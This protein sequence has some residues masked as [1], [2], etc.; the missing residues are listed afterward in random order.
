MNRREFLGTSGRTLAALA[1]ASALPGC[2]EG[3]NE[4]AGGSPPPAPSLGTA[5]AASATSASDGPP[6]R[7][8]L[9][10]W[11]LNRSHFGDWRTD[12][13]DAAG[14]EFIRR[15]GEAPATVLEGPLDPLDFP[16]RAAA[17]GFGGVE[18][19]NTFYYANGNDRGYLRELRNRAV[20]AG[21]ENVLIMCDGEGDLGAPALDDR[22]A[23]VERHQ[24]WLDAAEILGCHA[25]RVNA[26]S[27]GTREEQLAHAADGL[28]RLCERAE[29]QGLH[30]LVENHGGYSSD[31]AW[32]MEVMER[33]GHPL[34]GT[35]PDFGNFEPG[36]DIYQSVRLMM[37]LARAVSAKSYNFDEAGNE[38]TID[39]ARMMEIVRQAGYVGWV[40]VEYEGDRLREEEGIIAT[41]KL[42]ERLGVGAP[43]TAG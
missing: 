40:G 30:I 20:D 2:N 8:S 21:T 35:L 31:A 6:S 3:R 29:D 10:Q 19:V 17:L 4:A 13:G 15:L 24:R 9:A 39:F 42:L 43:S 23:S 16:A 36:Q 11:S 41:R 37:P 33:T 7:L 27:S 14:D 18:Y 32:L 34:V 25:I 5:A 1:M 26:Y 22:L 12:F 28:R 38:T